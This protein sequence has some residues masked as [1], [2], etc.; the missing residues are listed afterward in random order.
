MQAGAEAEALGALAAQE[1]GVEG[2]MVQ[3]SA[4]GLRMG[5]GGVCR[6][7]QLPVRLCGQARHGAARAGLPGTQQQTFTGDAFGLGSIGFRGLGFR[8]WRVCRQGL[9]QPAALW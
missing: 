5:G 8:V 6:G 9:Q 3:G 1:I 2:F 4:A 7:V